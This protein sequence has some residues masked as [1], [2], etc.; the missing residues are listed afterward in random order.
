MSGKIKYHFIRNKDWL[1]EHYIVKN[2]SIQKIADAEG[3]P[4]HVIRV[5]LLKTGIA[6]KPQKIYGYVNHPN[7]KGANHPR[8]KGGQ[9]KC[10]DCSTPITFGRKRCKQCWGLSNRGKNNANWKEVKK[11]RESQIARG[12]PEYIKWRTE[13]FKNVGYKC[14][15]CGEKDRKGVVHHLDS[16]NKFPEKRLDADNGV[17]LCG[18]H[19]NYFHLNYGFGNNTKEQFYDYLS[20]LVE[21][22]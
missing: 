14:Y 12:S 17:V 6:M 1:N 19:H 21:I 20:Q 13:L 15:I 7:R 3:F 16:F 2:M 11:T 8:W 18:K 10:M 9:H 4:Y 22:I 5:A